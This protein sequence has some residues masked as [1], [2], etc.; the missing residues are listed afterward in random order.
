MENCYTKHAESPTFQKLTTLTAANAEHLNEKL[1]VL[2][3]VAV[4]QLKLLL[5]KHKSCQL[6]ESWQL[7]TLKLLTC[8]QFLTLS[9]K[10]RNVSL[11]FTLSR[12]G[13]CIILAGA[14]VSD[15][16]VRLSETSN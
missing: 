15:S 12:I 8:N 10:G 5:S 11:K 14:V 1:S 4:L 16:H 9:T 3:V 6:R 2:K 13:N 7:K